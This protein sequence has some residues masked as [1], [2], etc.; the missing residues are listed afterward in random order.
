MICRSSALQAVGFTDR[1]TSRLVLG[2]AAI[3]GLIGYFPGAILA[4]I[5]YQVASA[6]IQIPFHM[7]AVRALAV[8]VATM[9]MCG[10]SAM[11]AIRKAQTADPADVF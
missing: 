9:V 4:V 11:I 2:Q 1:H 8:L 10:V 5:V 6:T 3:L 7:T